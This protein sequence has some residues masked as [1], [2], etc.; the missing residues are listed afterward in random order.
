MKPIQ[1]IMGWHEDWPD[2]S[3]PFKVWF[4][5]DGHMR[6]YDP[7]PTIEEKLSWIRARTQG[8]SI[9]KQSFSHWLITV[10]SPRYMFSDPDL[11]KLLDYTIRFLYL[12][13]DAK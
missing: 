6:Q 12:R 11:S 5:Q 10:G 9:G 7:T 8:Y 13:G 4:D 1:E 2:G 3:S